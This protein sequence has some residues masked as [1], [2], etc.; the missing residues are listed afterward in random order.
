MRKFAIT[1]SIA[2]GIALTVVGITTYA[3]NQTQTVTG[4]RYN[5]VYTSTSASINPPATL[6]AQVQ[7]HQDQDKLKGYGMTLNA[8]AKDAKIDAQTAIQKAGQAFPE[9]AGKAK[10]TIVEH[11]LV[12][13]E[14]F[15]GF[16]AQALQKNP[17][18]AKK[19]YMDHADVYI[20]T[21]TGMSVPSHVPYNFKGEV[22]IH[23]EYNVVI[24]A[25]TG[26]PLMGFSYR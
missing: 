26:E 25:K 16:S 10:G 19:G 13:N 17:E 4:A 12:T 11:Q 22:P 3:S 23:T 9:W 15:R 7:T 8:H 14:K 21:Y 6:P 1:G 2:L 24:D 20:V 5:S 18:L